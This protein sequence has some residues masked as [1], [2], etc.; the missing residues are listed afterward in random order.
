VLVEHGQDGQRQFIRVDV[1]QV[2]QLGGSRHEPE[3]YAAFC[4]RQGYD[5]V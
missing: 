3:N 1:S 2:G 5:A 4:G